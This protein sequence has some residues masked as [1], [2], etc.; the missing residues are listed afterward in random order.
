[1]SAL[2]RR[3]GRVTIDERPDALIVTAPFISRRRAAVLA[4][5]IV[6]FFIVLADF[7]FGAAGPRHTIDYIGLAVVFVG[8][9]YPALVL[10]L[11]GTVTTVRP[12]WIVV[13]RGPIPMWPAT[14]IDAAHVEDVRA[15]IATGIVGRGGRMA[16]DTIVASLVGGRSATLVDDA[17][18]TADAEQVAAAITTWLWSHRT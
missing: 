3:I 11:N 7:A 9:G 4:I 14:T 1:L 2:G 18:E 5:T 17:G 8:C 10:A 13:R 6:V 16:L 15:A 12:D